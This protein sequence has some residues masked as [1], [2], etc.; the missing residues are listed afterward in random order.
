MAD[1]KY[2]IE[3]DFTQGKKAVEDFEKSLDDLGKTSG[4]TETKTTGLWKQVAMGQFAYDAAK[5]AGSLFVDFMKT[6]IT[7]SGEAE[8]ADKSLAAALEI[9][10]RPVQALSEHFKTFAES[11]QRATTYE[12]D[13]VKGAQ[14]LLIQLT[15]LDRD[16]IDRATKGT[17]GLASVMNMDLQSAAMVV[18]KAVNGNAGALGRY[19]IQIDG[20]KDKE[21]QRAEVLSKLEKFYARATAETDT[22]SGKLAQ[23]KNK[24]SDIQEAAGNAL[25]KGLQPFMDAIKNPSTM[26]GFSA[27]TTRIAEALGFIASGY[28]YIAELGVMMAGASKDAD[29]WAVSMGNVKAAQEQEIKLTVEALRLN[30]ATNQ[31][32]RDWQVLA[33]IDLEQ[34]KTLLTQSELGKGLQEKYNEVRKQTIKEVSSHTQG[35]IKLVESET[36]VGDAIIKT[37]KGLADSTK[38]TNTLTSA[39]IKQKKEVEKDTQEWA[40]FTKRLKENASQQMMNIPP[41]EAG[42]NAWENVGTKAKKTFTEIAAGINQMSGEITRVADNVVGTFMTA[43]DLITAGSQQGYT[44][45]QIQMDNDYKI[46]MDKLKKKLDMGLITEKEY[47][48][49]IELLDKTQV[50]KTRVLRRDMAESQKKTA[51]IQALISTY[52][53]VAQTFSTLGFP[54][55]VIPAAAMLK[56]GLDNVNRIRQQPIPLAK[57]AIFKNPANLTSSS[58]GQEYQVAEAGEAEII[59]SPKRLREAI[60]GGRGKGG[61]QPVTIHNYIYLDGKL[62]KDFTVKTI[63]DASQTGRLRISAKAIT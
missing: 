14:T 37:A 17:I 34:A 47:N 18:E 4:V 33:K 56:L 45:R 25:I 20:T 61:G 27:A 31:Q 58:T 19:G 36:K 29:R 49:G 42:A 62:M 28:G 3:V 35:N 44:N 21:T 12:D 32:M 10:G 23:L 46:S 9:T 22:Y 57:G 40:D 41:L 50:E 2:L 5:K 53:A 51:V 38:S 1:I 54:W 24:Y 11:M 55:G 7:A 30:G 15:N 63:Q 6:S 26:D 13:V 8:K 52:Q 16:G 60:N 48:A 43:F 39:V 59:S